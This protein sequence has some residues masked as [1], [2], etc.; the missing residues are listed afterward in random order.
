MSCDTVSL[1]GTLSAGAQGVGESGFPSGVLQVAFGL[2]GSTPDD[3][4]KPSPQKFWAAPTI[5]SPAAYVT[6]GGVGTGQSVTQANLLY[7]RTIAA[8]NFRLT[9]LDPAGG[10]D[11]VA[12]I[13]AV[14]GLLILE[15]SVT[16]YLK[17]LE[18]K[19]VG[20][21]EYFASGNL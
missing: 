3:G 15:P 6:L 10:A 14:L 19:G 1:L 13:P 7:L 4:S 16:G 18:V 8:M 11:I 12:I 17:L 20:K 5:N 21:V 9:F 2:A